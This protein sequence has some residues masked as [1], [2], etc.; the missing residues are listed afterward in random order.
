MRGSAAG[1]VRSPPP[2]AREGYGGSAFDAFD[3]GVETFGFFSF[4]FFGSRRRA[5]LERSRR[6]LDADGG[7]GLEAK[8]VPRETGKKVRLAH[9]GVADEDHLEQVVIAAEGDGRRAER[10][11]GG[12]ER[13]GGGVRRWGFPRASWRRGREDRRTEEARRGD[14]VVVR[15]SGRAY[16]GG[17]GSGPRHTHSSLSFAIATRGARQ[18]GRVRAR[19][20]D[21]PSS[22]GACSRRARAEVRRRGP[23]ARLTSGTM[24]WPKIAHAGAADEI[25][26]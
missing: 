18:T 11:R 1:G 9:A 13:G 14:A 7:L 4:F 16:R 19:T 25:V 15:G 12:S 20:L 26:C 6:E 3:V 17:G 8:L 21:G 10:R 24:I 5:H 22:A 2:V 23:E